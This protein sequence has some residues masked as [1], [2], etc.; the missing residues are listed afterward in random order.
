MITVRIDSAKAEKMIRG[1]PIK[2]QNQIMPRIIE[3][4]T[5]GE[6]NNTQKQILPLS[7][8]GRL[9]NAIYPVIF[10]KRGEVR[11]APFAVR[12]ATALEEGPQ[13]IG[14]SS[15]GIRYNLNKPGNQ[16]L[17]DWARAKGIRKN[18]IVV[19]G[20]NTKFGKPS[21]KFITKSRTGRR[22]RLNRII[23]SEIKKL[24]GK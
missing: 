6:F 24:G 21:H 18:S 9:L 23:R 1:V 22:A 14:I 8:S 2:L 5:Y 16:R 19:G 17:R 15:M 10:K 7:Y 4:F 3:R 20:P 11:I 12:Q 13:A